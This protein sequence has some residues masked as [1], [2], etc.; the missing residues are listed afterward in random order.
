[1]TTVAENNASQSQER[2]KFFENVLITTAAMELVN[3]ENSN[4][5]GNNR[6]P[7]RAMK[8][9]MDDLATKGVNISR[10]KLNYRKRI[11]RE[12]KKP[13][14][15]LLVEISY[16]KNNLQTISTITNEDELQ[17]LSTNVDNT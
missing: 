12:S 11:V 15:E 17:S 1:M 7:H 8:A 10:N 5:L 14:Q 6:L 4:P 13:L 9:V 2:V 16:G 3:L